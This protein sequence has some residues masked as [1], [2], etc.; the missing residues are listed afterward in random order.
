[1]PA[2]N[3]GVELTKGNSLFEIYVEDY[4][5]YILKECSL[6]CCG[7]THSPFLFYSKNIRM[8]QCY[9]LF[10]ETKWNINYEW[11][12]I[13]Y[14]FNKFHQ[15]QYL[16]KFT[17][18]IIWKISMLPRCI[19]CLTWTDEQLQREKVNSCNRLTTSWIL[20][21]LFLFIYSFIFL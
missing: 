10:C 20:S 17:I 13:N 12:F 2:Y 19:K 8:H 4:K 5:C 14:R 18:A 7:H 3:Q 9:E 15:I 16:K 6:I 11:F 1:M 21:C